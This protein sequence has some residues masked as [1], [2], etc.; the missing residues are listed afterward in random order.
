MNISCF[1]VLVTI[2]SN[3]SWEEQQLFVCSSYNLEQHWLGRTAAVFVFQLKLGAA[4]VRKNSSCFCVLVTIWSNTGWKEQQ[5]FLC[6]SYNLEHTGWNKQQLFFVFQLKL[7]AALVGKNI[8]CYCVLD[9]I[10]STL[11]GMNSSCFCVLVKIWST[12]VGINSSCF[13]VLVKTWSSTGQEE[14]QLFLCSSYNLEQH[15]L[16]RTAAV[17]EFQLQF[18]AH[19]LE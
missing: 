12:L 15:W 10:W 6:S 3:T 4:L 13:C 9:K 1:C 7:G 5:L 19:W 14:Q 17:F 16:E 11:V 2:W 8:S 18:G